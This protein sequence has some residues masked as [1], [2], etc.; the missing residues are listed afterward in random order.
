M[1][2]T[3]QYRQQTKSEVEEKI[4]YQNMKSGRHSIYIWKYIVSSMPERVPS[5]NN[6][7]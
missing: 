1:N 3:P 5:N 7:K 4:T 2:N 6:L